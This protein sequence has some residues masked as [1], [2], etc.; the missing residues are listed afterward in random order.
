M[1]WRTVVS[2]TLGLAID[3]P[4]R[5]WDRT[6][7]AEARTTA[8]ELNALSPQ[9]QNRF[10]RTMGDAP[11]RHE[12][13][14]VLGI[15][16]SGPEFVIFTDSAKDETDVTAAIQRRYGGTCV[17]SME[18]INDR[19][20]RVFVKW[21]KGADLIT[22]RCRIPNVASRIFFN[23]SEGI[24]AF[25]F[26]NQESRFWSKTDLEPQHRPGYDSFIAR[27]LRFVESGSSVLSL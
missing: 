26:M 13:V 11:V 20:S 9:V 19:E 6:T 17:V 27:S 12:R 23:K 2:R 5:V 3:V 16:G 10:A 14:I 21:E 15:Q 24:L 22:T 25:L 8:D 4:E 1:A 18:Q 7:E